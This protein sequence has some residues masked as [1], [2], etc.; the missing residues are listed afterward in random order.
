ML[1]CDLLVISEV[2]QN[3]VCLGICLEESHGAIVLERR[4]VQETW[5][6]FQG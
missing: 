6:I 3:L 1:N 5:L 2:K 4:E